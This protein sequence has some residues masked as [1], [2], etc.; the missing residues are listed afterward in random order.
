MSTNFEDL[1]GRGSTENKPSAGIPGRLY[2]D[3]TLGQLERDTG[4][5][6]EVCEP[7]GA[8]LSLDD[9]TDVSIVTPSSGD[10]ITYSGSTWIASP[11][12]SNDV[13]LSDLTDVTLDSPTT[14][15]VLTYSGDGWIASTIE[16][17]SVALSDLTDVSIP[18]PSD[19]QILTFSGTGWVAE[20]P[21]SSSIVRQT[22]LTFT[23]AITVGGNPL[24]IYNQLGSNQTI[25]KVFLAVGTAPTGAS[26]IADIHKNGTT[27]FT[28]QNNRPNI[29]S[30]EYTGYTET[31]D[32]PTWSGGEY[33]TAH[34]DQI[35]SSVAGSD[36]VV[37]IIHN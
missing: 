24:R 27:I 12:P 8:S 16:S 26:I 11:I 29:A 25:S 6:W 10:V 22:I 5:I 31:I 21:I 32:V 23:G 14:G 3:T 15:D 13:A 35:G 17:S 28:N 37:H 34:V 33:L 18:S 20:N 7:S 36:L 30:G 1:I 4:L 9:L 19:G 2:Y